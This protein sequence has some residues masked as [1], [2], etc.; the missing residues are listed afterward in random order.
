MIKYLDEAVVEEHPD[1]GGAIAGVLADGLL[2]D[3]L[4]NG[5]SL[6]ALVTVGP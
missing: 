1:D 5:L 6:G 4:H 3:G 2:H